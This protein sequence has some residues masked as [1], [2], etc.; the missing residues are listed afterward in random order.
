MVTVAHGDYV[1]ASEAT[2]AFARHR[3]PNAGDV[4]RTHG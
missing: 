2:H 4:S 3:G 1:D